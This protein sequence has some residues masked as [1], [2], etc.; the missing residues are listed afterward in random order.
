M[1][2]RPFV[3]HDHIED[4]VDD[5]NRHYSDSDA[6][7]DQSIIND[8]LTEL[9]QPAST[10]AT[11]E[12]VMIEFETIDAQHGMIY[13]ELEQVQEVPPLSQSLPETAHSNNTRQSES[14]SLPE[15]TNRAL[16]HAEP[17]NN[18]P[19]NDDVGPNAST[20]E[21]PTRI[22]RNNIT[23]YILREEPVPKTYNNFLVHEFQAKPAS[24]KFMQRKSAIL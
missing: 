16:P 17:E 19:V 2:L 22:T 23:W 21:M 5:A 13:Y 7:D 24:V 12:V 8:N 3:P 1:R 4:V 11:G 15:Q 20:S 10:G 6:T 18:H 9:E 14:E